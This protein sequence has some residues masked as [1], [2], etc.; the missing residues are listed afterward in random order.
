MLNRSSKLSKTGKKKRCKFRG[1]SSDLA[2]SE[3]AQVSWLAAAV[4]CCLTIFTPP[5]IVAQST[6]GPLAKLEP[7]ASMPGDQFGGAVSIS[8]STL[9]VGANF[10]DEVAEDAGAAFVFEQEGADWRLSDTIVLSEGSEGDGFGFAVAIDGDFAIISALGDDE[11]GANAGAAYVFFKE[12]PNWTLQSKL[13]ANDGAAN[14]AFGFSVAISG[15]LALI[16]A[17]GADAQGNSAGAAYLFIR[18]N[19]G[20]VQLNKLMPFDG[21][22]GDFFGTSVALNENYAVVGALL[23]NGS[24]EN[25]GAAYI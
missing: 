3:C 14:D 1:A 5:A 19:T 25:A 8:G 10:H 4:V 20:W 15:D 18:S 21:S 9:I 2:T 7:G 17:R 12:G 11:I 23:A 6:I 16:G 22:A 13:T 24:E